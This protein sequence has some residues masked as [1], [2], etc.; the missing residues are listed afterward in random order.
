MT[1]KITFLVINW[2]LLNMASAFAQ[3]DPIKIT[4][5]IDTYYA[6]D[7]NEPSNHERPA[8]LYNHTRHNEIN[9]NLG[10]LKISYEKEGVYAN[11]G[12]MVG[13]YP[14]Y[15]LSSE[16]S[17]TQHI[18]EA[19]VGVDL[20]KRIRID[21]GIMGSHIGWES[22]VSKDN[23]TLTR[24]MAAENSPYYLSAA[25]ITHLPSAAWSLSLLIANGWQR[26]KRLD[27]NSS[28]AAG[29][30]ISYKPNDRITLNYST[31]VGNDRPDSAR[32][33]RFFH[34][35]YAVCQWSQKFSFIAGIDYGMEQTDKNPSKYGTWYGW[36]LI[37]KHQVLSKLSFAGRIEQFIDKRGIVVST[38]TPHGFQT[39]GFSLNT[40]FQIN[41]HALL[42]TEIRELISRDKV[43]LKDHT[44]KKTNLAWTTSLSVNF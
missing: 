3:S 28:P 31:F 24:S 1:R 21:A 39:N 16:A 13:T 37:A 34:D 2:I 4:G 42:R 35:V 7:F 14:Q 25:K 5:F 12:F 9:V 41:D 19:N 11:L 15:N 44:S 22:A 27:Q 18:Y 32:A 33:W 29:T 8:F 26:V 6:Y 20:T 17:S 38:T 36:A 23:V 30:Q 10:L 40:D 43:F